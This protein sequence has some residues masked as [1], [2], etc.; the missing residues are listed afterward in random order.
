MS[1]STDDIERDALD[2]IKQFGD[3]ATRI[4]RLRAEI[5]RKNIR[6]QRLGQTWHDIANAIERL[7]P[8]P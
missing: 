8:K 4:A 5:A 7:Y 6:N 3:A 1:N 2:M